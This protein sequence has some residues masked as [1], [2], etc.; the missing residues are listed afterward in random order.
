MYA[1]FSYMLFIH[2]YSIYIKMR[3]F[4]YA[5]LMSNTSLQIIRMDRNT[6]YFDGLCVKI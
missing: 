3:V 4:I 5:M 2:K 1:F 6:S